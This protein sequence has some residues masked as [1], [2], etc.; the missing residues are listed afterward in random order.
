M[1]LKIAWKY[2][3]TSKSPVC[4]I[5]NKLLPCWPYLF[6]TTGTKIS[7]WLLFANTSYSVS[8]LETEALCPIKIGL[9]FLLQWQKYKLFLCDKK[10][11]ISYFL[12]FI[13]FGKSQWFGSWTI[14]ANFE[15][16]TRMSGITNCKI[17][18]ISN[19]EFPCFSNCISQNTGP[20]E[21]ESMVQKT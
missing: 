6:I 10:C 1:Y 20:M 8:L 13:D 21:K 9:L 3:I 11:L 12:M 7:V 19:P 2:F 17:I 18:N 4:T 16:W 14:W 5:L 15:F